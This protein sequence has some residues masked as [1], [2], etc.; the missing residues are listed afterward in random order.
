MAVKPY[1]GYADWRFLEY[2]PEILLARLER[3]GVVGNET[4]LTDTAQ[5]R[6]YQ[7]DV[8]EDNPAGMLD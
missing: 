7:E 2:L 4:H 5:T 1:H 3:S 6:D 8:F